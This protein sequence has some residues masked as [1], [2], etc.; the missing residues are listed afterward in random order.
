M[1]SRDGRVVSWNPGAQRI[2]QY[3]AHELRTPLT[4][5]GLQLQRLQRSGAPAEIVQT[6]LRSLRRLGALMETL[7]D[8]SRIATGQLKL[9]R[10]DCDLA[11]LVREVAERWMEEA[12]R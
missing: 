2:K 10:Q 5:L 7:F 4:A 9:D 6:A 11:D 8:V 3:A 12:A 1:L